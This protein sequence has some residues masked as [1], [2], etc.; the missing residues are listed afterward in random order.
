MKKK[1]PLIIMM[2]CILILGI[3]SIPAFSAD[4]KTTVSHTEEYKKWKITIVKKIYYYD[5]TRIRIFQDMKSDKS[6]EKSFVD[7]A[8]KV[9]IRLIR[10]DKGE[11]TK[12]Q[13]ISKE[14]ADEILEDYSDGEDA[15][16]HALNSNS[17]TY[18]TAKDSAIKVQTKEKKKK[19]SKEGELT[20]IK[21]YL[22]S[23][24]PLKV[25]KAIKKCTG[26]GFYVI[27]SGTRQYIYYN[28]L[29]KDYAYQI[30]GTALNIYDIGSKKDIYVLLSLPK[31][32]SFTLSY[33]SDKINYTKITA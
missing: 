10:N 30:N 33:N 26:E 2:C 13:Y 23:E 5:K 29:T 18:N 32:V 9:D 1:T 31:E 4:A 17:D 12:L 19:G 25:Q 22:V 21:R 8:G 15:D 28:H 3:A 24:V 11:I 27:E 20:D 6:F 7:K 16:E 14:E